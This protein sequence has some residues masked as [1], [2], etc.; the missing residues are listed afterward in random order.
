M[1]NI[2]SIGS[3]LRIT[4]NLSKND[5]SNFDLLN[6][7]QKYNGD[8]LISEPDIKYQPVLK[9]YIFFEENSNNIDS[10]YID[11]LSDLVKNTLKTD[12]TTVVVE[13]F[14]DTSEELNTSKRRIEN[15]LKILT[16]LGLPKSR[17]KVIDHAHNTA[18]PATEDDELK[19]FNRRV[20][21]YIR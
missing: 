11:S 7:I 2:V 4:Y 15:T 8:I 16:S 1:I 10:A 9:L 5:N 6:S 17:I 20:H 12:V 19:K 21:I 14:S 13:G 18:V 3:N